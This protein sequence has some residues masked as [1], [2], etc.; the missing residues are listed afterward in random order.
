[1]ISADAFKNLLDERMNNPITIAKELYNQDKSEEE[2]KDE[3]NKFMKRK[4]NKEVFNPQNQD[5]IF[6]EVFFDLLFDTRLRKDNDF[7]YIGYLHLVEG[8]FDHYIDNPWKIA[9]VYQI[10]PEY[11]GNFYLFRFTR[12]TDL[13]NVKVGFIDNDYKIY[14]SFFQLNNIWGNKKEFSIESNVFE[15]WFHKI[16]NN[17]ITI[18]TVNFNNEEF[19]AIPERYCKEFIE[20]YNFPTAYE[21]FGYLEDYVE[22]IEPEKS[23][24]GDVYFKIIPIKDDGIIV[25]EETFIDI[26]TNEEEINGLVR[27]ESSNPKGP[28]VFYESKNGNGDYRIVSVFRCN[29]Y[30]LQRFICYYFNLNNKIN[31]ADCFDYKYFP[32]FIPENYKDDKYEEKDLLVQNIS[33]KL[34][35]CFKDNEFASKEDVKDAIVK[36]IKELKI[37][38]D[39]GAY[40]AAIILAGSI[41]EAVLIQWLSECYKKD[42]F[43]KDCW[44]KINDEDSDDG[45]L[46]KANTLDK[47]IKGIQFLYGIED[48]PWNVKEATT[49]K[50]KRNLVHAK[51]FIKDMSIDKDTCSAVFEYLLHIINFWQT[52][53][54]IKK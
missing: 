33:V 36:D 34:Y 11:K 24:V 47:Y 10:I 41:L 32:L 7:W 8:F 18:P 31:L 53:D 35:N 25:G 23:K 30:Y 20:T 6:T 27:Y 37:C 19:F 5:I 48:P 26:F 42:F 12:S 39:N 49:I 21:R 22:F 1:M 2:R 14:N 44:I 51:L 16:N 15:S 50:E 43:N 40:K 45:I 17:T 52:H 9:E 4:M 46:T 54:R 29:D 38:S 28:R 13:V 3:I